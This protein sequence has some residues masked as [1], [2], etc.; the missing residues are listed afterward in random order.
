MAIPAL[1]QPKLSGNLDDSSKIG[2]GEAQNVILT[3]K[4]SKKVLV[5]SDAYQGIMKTKDMFKCIFCGIDME[6]DT[7]Y[8]DNHINSAAHKH[9]MRTYPHVEDYGEN[10][11]RKLNSKLCFCTICNIV[12]LYPFL[13]HHIAGL[14]HTTELKK[15]LIRATAY[16]A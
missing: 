4:D 2:V 7:N 14:V 8:K 5:T 16:D 9:R 10:L 3:L 13:K 1:R 11:I 15:A 12:V 6:L